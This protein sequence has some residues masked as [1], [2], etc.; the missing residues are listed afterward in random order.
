MGTVEE[1]ILENM[2]IACAIL[3]VGGTEPEIYLWGHL[4]PN[5]NVRFKNTIA[6]LGLTATDQKLQKS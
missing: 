5:C 1:L 4:P 2:G 3:S 6:T